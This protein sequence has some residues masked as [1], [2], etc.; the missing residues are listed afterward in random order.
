MTLLEQQ[1]S[2]RT[3]TAEIAKYAEKTWDFSLN[4]SAY[5]AI[6][7]VKDCVADTIY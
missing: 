1:T 7:A 4:F 6:S 5:S 3:F 2:A